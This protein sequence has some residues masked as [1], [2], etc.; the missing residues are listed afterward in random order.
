ME[1]SLE[2]EVLPAW[3]ALALSSL[4][5]KGLISS[6]YHQHLFALGLFLAARVCSAHN[7][8]EIRGR[9]PPWLSLKQ[10]LSGAGVP[11]LP[12]MDNRE[13]SHAPCFWIRRHLNQF[14]RVV[15]FIVTDSELDESGS[16]YSPASHLSSN[17]T[18]ALS[19]CPETKFKTTLLRL[20]LPSM[21]PGDASAN[22]SSWSCY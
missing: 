11:P 6:T 22:I 1:Y 4:V 15:V 20:S 14:T 21:R 10:Q 2:L 18:S 13:V 16:S 5:H 3:I 17:Y 7:R 19:T 8:L 12:R 9:C